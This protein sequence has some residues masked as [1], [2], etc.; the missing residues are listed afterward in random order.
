MYNFIYHAFI[1]VKIFAKCNNNQD[2]H[3][4]SRAKIITRIIL[5]TIIYIKFIFNYLCSDFTCTIPVK[6]LDI[7]F[8]KNKDLSFFAQ[9]LYRIS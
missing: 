9:A 4:S 2:Y 7:C 8:L 1:I 6:Q 3:I 5:K